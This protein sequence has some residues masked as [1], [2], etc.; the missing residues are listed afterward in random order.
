MVIYE[1]CF[2]V[3]GNNVIIVVIIFGDFIQIE[4]IDSGLNNVLFDFDMGIIIISDNGLGF[5]F[6]GFG[7]I[8]GDK[9]LQ[10][11]DFFCV[12]VSV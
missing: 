5:G 12:L 3:F 11:G 4:V 10:E 1:V 7:I 2:N 8:V 9:S 6:D